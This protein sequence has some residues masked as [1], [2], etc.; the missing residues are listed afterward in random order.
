MAE[1]ETLRSAAASSL[2][3]RLGHKGAQFEWCGELDDTRHW[4]L[5]R[6]RG[7]G[8]V[9]P[10]AVGHFGNVA[11]ALLALSQAKVRV[12]DVSPPKI[13]FGG[14]P[15]YLEA[16][17]GKYV[18]GHASA[19][20]ATVL[21]GVLGLLAT[22]AIG[23]FIGRATKSDDTPAASGQT[24]AQRAAARAVIG[25]ANLTAAAGSGAGKALGVAQFV[26]RN[27]QNII[28]VLADGLPT[29][30]KGSGYGVWMTGTGQKPVWLGYFQAVT[31]NGQ[32]GAQSVL[33]QNPR[34]F[35]S[36]LI[37]R[38]SGRNPTSP[39]STYLTGKIVFKSK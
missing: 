20:D 17:R 34:L 32:V 22:L 39:G 12:A 33:K 35:Q 16:S 37:T 3:H 15:R 25:Q 14:A 10:I 19:G 21:L 23:F 30:P 26:Q 31:T 36:V 8:A 6:V 24:A 9:N 28:S 38:E 2:F 18:L 7:D 1:H 27:G 5:T 29:A 13:V 4:T 11:A